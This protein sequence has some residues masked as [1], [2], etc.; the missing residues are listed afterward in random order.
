MIVLSGTVRIAPGRKADAAPH[1]RSIVAA[2]RAEPGCLA[3]SFAYDVEDPDLVRIFE[4]YADDDALA[5]HRAAP[6]FA[7]WRAAWAQA[8]IGDRQMKEFRV[9]QAKD[10]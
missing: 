2:S 10:I 7:A 6:H 5:A 8:G 3:Y 4:I 9:S 1:I